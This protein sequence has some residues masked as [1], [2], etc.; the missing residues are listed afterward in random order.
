MK[1][2]CEVAQAGSEKKSSMEMSIREEAGSLQQ[3]ASPL[4]R[5]DGSITGAIGDDSV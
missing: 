4:T 2:G 3:G 5:D 1:T